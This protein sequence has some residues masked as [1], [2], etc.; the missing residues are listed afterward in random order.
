[1]GSRL[2]RTR[3]S[4]EPVLTGVLWLDRRRT[5]AGTTQPRRPRGRA[6]GFGRS[7]SLDR[8]SSGG[9]EPLF[10][11]RFAHRELSRLAKARAIAA[12]K[13][14]EHFDADD[15]YWQKT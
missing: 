3:M 7:T 6:K 13:Q 15:Y 2:A 10:H 12:R 1:M 11:S 4:L 8:F 5:P 14:W 9:C